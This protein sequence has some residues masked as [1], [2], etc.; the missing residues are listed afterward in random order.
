M[1]CKCG[2]ALVCIKCKDI[3]DRCECDKETLPAGYDYTM[4]EVDQSIK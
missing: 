2:R 1:D 3:P 4:T